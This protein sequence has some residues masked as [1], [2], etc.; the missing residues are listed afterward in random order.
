LICPINTELTTVGRNRK[1]C[2]LSGD[3]IPGDSCKGRKK[4]KRSYGNEL[5]EKW[6]CR[7]KPRMDTC[8]TRLGEPSQSTAE[9]GDSFMRRRK[10][11]GISFKRKPNPKAPPG[12][13]M[14][15]IGRNCWSG[16]GRIDGH[17]PKFCGSAMCCR[18]GY[19]KHGCDG[20]GGGAIAHMCVD[21]KASFA[22]SVKGSANSAVAGT[23][24]SG[25]L[26]M[27]PTDFREGAK[28]LM[29]CKDKKK[30]LV[31]GLLQGDRE[32]NRGLHDVLSAL[33]LKLGFNPVGYHCI[34]KTLLQEFYFNPFR[35]ITADA[36]CFRD[37]T[38]NCRTRMNTDCI[39]EMKEVSEHEEALATCQRKGGNCLSEKRSA[40]T[41]QGGMV[42][43]P[44][45]DMPVFKGRHV[46]KSECVRRCR[47]AGYNY[48]GRQGDPNHPGLQNC[49]CGHAY[50]RYGQL[51]LRLQDGSGPQ[52]TY[53]GY[54]HPNLVHPYHYDQSIFDSNKASPWKNGITYGFLKSGG[55]GLTDWWGGFRKGQGRPQLVVK[56]GY[57]TGEEAH[58]KLQ[59]VKPVQWKSLAEGSCSV[60]FSNAALPNLANC[61]YDTATS[62]FMGVE[63]DPELVRI[64]MTWKKKGSDGNVMEESVC[65]MAVDIVV[66]LCTTCCCDRGVVAATINTALIDAA[67]IPASTGKLDRE[68]YFNDAIE[69]SP[70]RGCK[71]WFQHMDL[72]S[73]FIL[74]LFRTMTATIAFKQRGCV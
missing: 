7:L 39:K 10:K 37:E 46:E 5:A 68:A 52:L 51:A 28:L 17:C 71:Q 42:S 25:I 4:E 32:C 34:C 24:T 3:T 29:K 31:S 69:A 74:N 47:A 41:A 54:N 11:I 58:K 55:K 60:P 40:D 33:L 8:K 59:Y 15:N 57:A 21:L 12:M 19:K 66:P 30:G 44:Q 65:R 36:T 64:L 61:V 50:G 49:F 14:K 6:E 1:N 23:V 48:A 16:C 43:C 56:G 20:R 70:D 53:G 63:S 72:F 13:P 38:N 73:R 67:G 2:C 27:L 26:K 45:R 35:V 18:K 22:D 62:R 9:L